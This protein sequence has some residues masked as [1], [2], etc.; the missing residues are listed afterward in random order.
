MRLKKN[1]VDMETGQM[2][3]SQGER[4]RA[5]AYSPF[6]TEEQKR[7]RLN[8]KYLDNVDKVLRPKKPN[9]KPT[10]KAL[11]LRKWKC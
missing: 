2:T 8:Q 5:E 3:G 1:T 9:G 4:L 6:E 7:K 10:R 11:A